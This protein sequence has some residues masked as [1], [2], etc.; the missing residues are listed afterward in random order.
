MEDPLSVFHNSYFFSVTDMK[1][2]YVIFF[3]MV[4]IA[5]KTHIA[6][7]DESDGCIIDRL[8]QDIRNGTSLR[9]CRPN[10]A[11]GKSI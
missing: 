1:H 8:L 7:A 9:R 5:G 11:E 3:M 10:T 4:F 6:S 2:I